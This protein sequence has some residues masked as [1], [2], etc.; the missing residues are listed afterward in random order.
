VRRL[1][2]VCMLLA[3]ARVAGVAGVARADA[4]QERQLAEQRCAAR[5]PQCDWLAT[6]STL[7]RGSV[8]RALA[9]RGYAVE[10][11]PW[12]KVIGRVHIYNEDVFAEKSAFLQ[13]FNLFHVT[14]RERAIRAELV[15]GEGAVW[16]RSW[17]RRPRAGCAI[18]CGARWSPCSRWPRRSPA[19]STC[20]SSRATSGACASTRSTCSRKA[21]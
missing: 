15:I 9:A 16:T 13:F 7:E 11:A 10:P 1:P 17:S 2:I 3:G 6:L 12:G 8:Q 4:R 14:T 5:D 20:S 19:R 18:R 21:S